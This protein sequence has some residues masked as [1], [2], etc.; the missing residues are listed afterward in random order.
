LNDEIPHLSVAEAAKSLGVSEW[1]IYG[2]IRK[3]LIKPETPGGQIRFTLAAIEEFRPKMPRRG[4]PKKTPAAQRAHSDAKA[5]IAPA[6][7]SHQ[8]KPVPSWMLPGSTG[9]EHEE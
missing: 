2:W 6:E 4:R 1:T 3:G 8:V 9:A 7:A 5:A